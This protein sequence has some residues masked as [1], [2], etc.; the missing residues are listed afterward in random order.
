MRSLGLAALLVLA[1][2]GDDDCCTME[3]HDAGI[4]VV[5]PQDAN[6]HLTEVALIAPSIN[7]D[8]DLLFVL[9][10]SSGMAG[11][12]ARLADEIPSFVTTLVRA[13]GGLPNLHV[14]FITTDLGTTGINNS[15]PGPAITA[16]A[17]D[18]AG[19]DGLLQTNGAAVAGTFVSSIESADGT[20][21]GNYT[22]DLNATLQQMASISATGCAFEQPLEAIHRGLTNSLNAGFLR[23]TARLAIIV[24][25][26]EDDCSLADASL[27]TADTTTLGRLSSFRC[28][29]FGVACDVGGTSSEEMNT[30]GTKF[31]CH[32]NDASPYLTPLSRYQSLLATLKPDARD[33]MVAAIVGPV[34]PFNVG[35]GTTMN[36]TTA[37][38]LEASC[39]YAAPLGTGV[40]QPAVRIAQLAKATPHGSV[41]NM[42]DA[43]FP[44]RIVELGQR[45]NGLVGNKCIQQ[46][47]VQPSSCEAFD[48]DGAGN[49]TFVPACVNTTKLPCFKLVSEPNACPAAQQLAVEVMR[50]A[51]V[52]PNTWTSVRCAV[53]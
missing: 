21:V 24:I 28:T 23:P 16:A 34:T 48:I 3:H 14:G 15:A 39:T 31:L 44:R 10:D 29:Q 32:S 18:G 27:L 2:C 26:D 7:R 37:S 41:T 22:G 52:A 17:C 4:D 25:S 13:P 20:R 9:D 36:G 12:L 43:D 42:C 5:L 6:T 53:L 8:L 30:P 38:Y 35:S 11:E 49:M 33:V 1:G 47:I 46:V 45:V 50:S 40:A 19:E 51:S